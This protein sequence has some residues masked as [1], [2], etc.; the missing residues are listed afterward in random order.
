MTNKRW[1]FARIKRYR[2]G[3]RS[4]AGHKTWLIW[5]SGMLHHAMRWSTCSRISKVCVC[6]VP[7]PGCRSATFDQNKWQ[8]RLP[9]VGNFFFSLT[10]RQMLAR[11][12]WF[13]VCSKR[14]EP[15]IRMCL[16]TW[17]WCLTNYQRRPAWNR[18]KLCCNGGWVLTDEVAKHFAVLPAP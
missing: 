5:T 3:K 11:V 13:T 12:Q 15:T 9:Y 14:Q 10:H 7:M 2:Y 18:L 6:T 17:V 8:K 4:S 1:R 16:S